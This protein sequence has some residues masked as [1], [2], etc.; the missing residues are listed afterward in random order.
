MYLSLSKL[1]LLRPAAVLETPELPRRP[2]AVIDLG[3]I[4]GLA[5]G[6]NEIVSSKPHYHCKLYYLI[7]RVVQL[8]YP[9]M[10]LFHLLQK[11]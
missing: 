7:A 2:P 6:L 11:C 1:I 5:H 8:I 9:T 3:L 10:Y 4:V